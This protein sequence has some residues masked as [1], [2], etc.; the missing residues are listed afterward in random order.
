ML[1]LDFAHPQSTPAQLEALNAQVASLQR[2]VL[3]LQGE[4]NT[5][6]EGIAA[7]QANNVQALDPFVSVDPNPEN[8]VAGPH[9]IFTGANVHIV[10]G[11][12][13]PTTEALPSGW[14]I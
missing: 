6:R 8:G 14:A 12:G 7:V 4:V 3:T 2:T 5:L 11:S 9:I 10:S 13:Q 1:L